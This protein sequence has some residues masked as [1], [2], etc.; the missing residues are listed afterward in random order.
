MVVPWVCHPPPPTPPPPLMNRNWIFAVSSCIPT[1]CTHMVCVPNKLATWCISLQGVCLM[2]VELDHKCI[3][4]IF[5]YSKH[6]CIKMVLEYFS[7][8]HRNG[9]LI[10]PSEEHLRDV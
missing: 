1:V 5:G 10:A 2:A 6:K 8:K 9:S 4:D 7:I 3:E